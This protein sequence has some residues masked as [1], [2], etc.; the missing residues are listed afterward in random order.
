MT[1]NSSPSHRVP[2]DG[3]VSLADFRR[4]PGCVT[5]LS[6]KD[7]AWL[8]HEVESED[9]DVSFITLMDEVERRHDWQAFRDWYIEVWD[10]HAKFRGY[11]RKA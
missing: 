3:L 4:A 10:D 2:L 1:G 8:T 9:D 5:C 11:E 6:C 7:L